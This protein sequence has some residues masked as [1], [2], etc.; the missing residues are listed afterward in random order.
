MARIIGAVACSHTPTIGF[1]LD[2]SKQQ[3]PVWAPIFEAFEPVQRW[4]EERQPDVLFVI[5]NDHV[6]SF[7][8]DHYS[9]FALGVGERHEVA[10]EGG[11]A[12]DLPALAGHPAMA[13]HIGRS[14]VADEFDMSFFQDRPLDHGV[15]SPLSLLCPHEPAWPTPVVPLQVGVLQS[16]APSARRCWRL[17]QAL[18]RAIESYPEDLKVAIVATG[19]LSHQVH[20]E[21]AGFNNTAWDAQF[22]DLIENDPVRLTEMTQAELATLGGLEGAEVIMWLVMRG[23]LSSNVRKTHQSY[24]LPSMTG[25]ATAIYEN[26]ASPPVAGEAKRHRRRIDE[27]LV[28]VEALEGT[29]P[30]TLETSVRALRLN[31]FLHGMT[32]PEHRARFL[33]DEEGAF[34]AAE[35]TLQEREL[36]RQRDWRGLIHYGVIFFMLEKL[37]AVLG[38]SNLHIYAA[39]RGQS[40]E[41]FQQTRNAPSALYSVAGKDA[42]PQTWNRS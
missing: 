11:G 36:V 7:F 21:R 37:G 42:A 31:K 16:P 10:D 39:M 13:R 8:F 18:R 38:V 1:A 25:I 33:A 20:G 12:R 14:L 41:A 27:Q 35:L 15:F 34:E 19:G 24:Y 6:S 9:A 17:G 30:F 28:G 32:R 2:K 40:L 29:Y 3:D 23:A 26:L 22:L 4:L 5:Y